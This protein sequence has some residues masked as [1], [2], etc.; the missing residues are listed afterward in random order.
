MLQFAP[1]LDEGKSAFRGRMGSAQKRAL[2]PGVFAETQNIRWSAGAMSVRWGSYQEFAAEFNSVGETPTDG[3]KFLGGGCWKWGDN[4]VALMAVYDPGTLAVRLYVRIRNHSLWTGPWY[5]ATAASGKWGAT[6]MSVPDYGHVQFQ[7]VPGQYGFRG[8]L[9]Q[10]GK[11][12][13]R[14]I[15]FNDFG[16]NTARIIRDVT[17]PAGVEPHAPVAGVIGGLDVASGTWTPTDSGAGATDFNA[18]VTG[19]AGSQYLSIGEVSAGTGVAAAKACSFE[20]PLANAVDFSSSAQLILLAWCAIDPDIWFKLK[21]ELGYG[22][23]PT[24]QTIYDPSNGADAPVYENTLLIDTSVAFRQIGIP[25]VDRSNLS[26]VRGIRFTALSALPANIIAKI[27]G[28]LASG[29]VQGGAQYAISHF[30]TFTRCESPAKILRINASESASVEGVPDQKSVDALRKDELPAAHGGMYLPGVMKAWSGSN[31][32]PALVVST[33]FYYQYKV[34]AFS[35]SSVQGGYGVDTCVIYRKDYG[36]EEFT[37]VTE[38]TTAQYSGG[39]WTQYS[40]F[41]AWQQKQVQTDNLARDY[42]DFS[43]RAP[44]ADNISPP[45][46]YSMTYSNGRMYSTVARGSSSNSAFNSIYASE[47]DFPFRFR[48]LP[49]NISDRKSES[50]GYMV[51]LGADEALKLIAARITGETSSVFAF[52]RESVYRL[53][54]LNPEP[55]AKVGT[56]APDS[57]VEDKGVLYWLDPNMNLMQWGGSLRNLSLDI[58][59]DVLLAVQ[60]GDRKYISAAAYSDHVYLAHGDATEH[61]NYKVLVFDVRVDTKER[62]GGFVS[63]DLY[64]ADACPAGFFLV[65]YPGHW[66]STSISAHKSWCFFTPTGAGMGFENPGSTTDAGTAI[67]V[68]IKSREFAGP[69]LV[70]TRRARVEADGQSNT[71]TSERITDLPVGTVT[72]E[73]PLTGSGRVDRFDSAVGTDA[74]IGSRSK[75]ASLKLSGNLDGGTKIYSIAME[76]EFTG[77][78][79]GEKL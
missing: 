18:A 4:N 10:S 21:I 75:A 49:H 24:W 44:A 14:Y 69:G 9:I 38:V 65:D 40:P 3:Y 54:G 19:A 48:A 59:S 6:R 67:P 66:Q 36:E 2:A 76:L 20:I 35:P 15:D 25:L 26:Q 57:C 42:K 41:S 58:E 71:L 37:Y 68:V 39:A 78:G 30:S 72:G 79:S 8:V 22:A 7:G 47:R 61:R 13:P 5:E 28:I 12:E 74:P 56:I 29:E 77:F 16:S 53:N 32:P 62:A 70:F 63:D 1:I 64:P 17:A 45:Q 27:I 50:S 51:S 73:L 34:P 52:C 33:S 43:R 46:G 23:T 11:E 31:V 60:K 55:L